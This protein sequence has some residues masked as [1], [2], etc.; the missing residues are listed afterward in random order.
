MAYLVLALLIDARA[1]PRSDL[2]R[3]P[4]WAYAVSLFALTLLFA[5]WFAPSGRPAFAAISALITLAIVVHI[6]NLKYRDVLEPVNFMDFTLTPQIWRHP[7]LY[8]AEFLRHWVFWVGVLLLLGVIALWFA[9]IEISVLRHPDR[10][11][12]LIA[13]SLATAI[14]VYLVF[15]GPL[16][17]TI[18]SAIHARLMPPDPARDVSVLGF[19]GATL[20]GVIAWR[21]HAEVSRSWPVMPPANE[22]PSPLVIVVQAESFVDLARIGLRD[23]SLPG[24]AEARAKSA[25]HGPLT[26]PVQGA[27]TLR[28]EYSFLTGLPLQVF[29]MD[30]L[31]PYWRLRHPPRTIAHHLRDHGFRTAF[32]HPFDIAFFNR[33]TAMPKLGFQRLIGEEAFADTAREGYYV[34]DLAVADRVLELVASEHAPLFCMA[35]TMENHNPWGR[36]RIAGIDDPVD[37]Y[38]YHLR[39]TDRMI[40]RLIAGIEAQP[41][42]AVFAFYG[43]HVPTLHELAEPFPDTRTDYVVMGW[44]DGTWLPGGKTGDLSLGQ[45]AGTIL[46]VLQQVRAGTV[47]RQPAGA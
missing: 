2:L 35:A 12:P 28:C 4:A 39:N 46:D 9:W 13:M 27:W 18:V 44:R 16:P 32:V 30:A 36:G 29:G 17:E 20:A 40:A 26:V 7:R 45:L 25:L 47:E 23:V 8:R 21:R 6:S 34:P 41:R 43:D 42:P 38:V 11:T 10:W 15:A 5:V 24:L 3:R 31:H 33:E 22:Q 14:M 19:A 37:Q 1:L